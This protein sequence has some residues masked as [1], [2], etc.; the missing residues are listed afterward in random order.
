VAAA[1]VVVVVIVV[2]AVGVLDE[3]AVAEAESLRIQKKLNV[4][5]WKPLPEDS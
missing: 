4:L 2:N 1:A 5:R 3:N